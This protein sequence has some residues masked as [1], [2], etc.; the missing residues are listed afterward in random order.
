MINRENSISSLRFIGDEL[1]CT[2][3]CMHNIIS[4]IELDIVKEALMHIIFT[5]GKRLRP[6]LTIL[7]AKICGNNSPKISRLAACI[8]LIH[9]A[10]LIHDDI[11]DHSDLR[12]GRKTINYLWN[13]NIG[14][15]VGDYCYGVA[16][17]SMT[18]Q[19]EPKILSA[20]SD[21]F[22]STTEGEVLE[23]IHTNNIQM[24]KDLYLQIIGKKTAVLF[25]VACKSG[26]ILAKAPDRMTDS[27]AEFGYN[28]GIAF[29][30]MDD[31]LDYTSKTDECGKKVGTDFTEGKIT[32]PII[33]ALNK[34][35]S[36]HADIIRELLLSNTKNKSLFNEVCSILNECGCINDTL[37]EMNV[38]VTKAKEI[39]SLFKP[40]LERNALTELLQH[41][42]I[43]TC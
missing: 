31:I 24:T 26:A 10:S 7:S 13:N 32:L 21:A 16:S 27:L 43:E 4:S 38:Y 35:S 28:F 33:F 15:L 6:S 34:V 30:I 29:Q 41:T 12:R 1:S 2:E 36:Q 9:T 18:E 8:E 39:L 19:F 3:K 23:L 42:F 40:S 5:G 37:N 17:K 25:G 11:L 22:I 14:V 20:L